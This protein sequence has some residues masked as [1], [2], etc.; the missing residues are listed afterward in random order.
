MANS[1]TATIKIDVN[2]NTHDID[3][4]RRK[5]A[6]LAAQQ[7]TLNKKT[8]A[9]ASRSNNAYAKVLGDRVN[10]FKEHFDQID[11]LTQKAGKALK[12]GIG[13]ASKATALEMAAMGASMLVVHAAFG[14][15]NFLMKAY[16]GGLQLLAVGAAAAGVAISSVAAAMREQAAAMSAFRYGPTELG[17]GI[18]TATAALRGL[19][20]DADLAFLGV[21]NLNAAFQAVNQHAKFDAGSQKMLKSLMDFGAASGNIEGSVKQAGDLVGL[22]QQI[23]NP[24]TGMAVSFMQIKQA[25]NALSPQLSEALRKLRITTK[26]GFIE[27]LNSGELAKAGGVEGQLGVVG[28]TLINQL[29]GYKTRL[30]NMF[31]DLGQPFLVPLKNGMEKIFNIISRSLRTLSGA[32]GG[33]G[34]NKFINGLVSLADKLSTSITK[35][36]LNYL[37]KA[38]GMFSRIGDWFGRVKEFFKSAVEK[39]RPLVDGAKVLEHAF[40]AAFT[41]IKE[42]ISSRFGGFNEFLKANADRAKD[43]GDKVGK[44]VASLLGVVHEFGVIYQN[45][46][47]FVTKL[48]SGA[49]SVANSFKDVLH[50]ITKIGTFFGGGEGGSLF[51]LLGLSGLAKGM[52]KTRGGYLNMSKNAG[53]NLISPLNPMNIGAGGA[54]PGPQVNGVWGSTAAGLQSAGS[55]LQSAGASLQSAAV[56][57]QSGKAT[58]QYNA[59]NGMFNPGAKNPNIIAAQQ[60]LKAGGWKSLTP[61]QQIALIND[62]KQRAAVK[63]VPVGGKAGNRY[64]ARQQWMRQYQVHKMKFYDE[65]SNDPSLSHLTDQEK[66]SRARTM[67]VQAMQMGPASRPSLSSRVK[68]LGQRKRTSINARLGNITNIA[69]SAAIDPMG[70]ANSKSQAFGGWFKNQFSQMTP[71]ELA[72]I[73][74]MKQRQPSWLNRKMSGLRNARERASVGNFSKGINSPLGSIGAS[75]GIG[76]LSQHVGKQS[77]G[78]MALGSM[79]AGSNPLAGLAVAGIGGAMGAQTSAGG[80]LLG[81]GGG[82]ALGMMVA[83]PAGAAVGAALGAIGGAIMGWRNGN[84]ARKKAARESVVQEMQSLVYGSVNAAAVAI[85]NNKNAPGTGNYFSGAVTGAFSDIATKSKALNDYVTYQKQH[86]GQNKDIVNAVYSNQRAYGINMSPEDRNTQLKAAGT[87][88]D[89]MQTESATRYKMAIKLSNAYTD[90]LKDLTSWTG[91]SADEINTLSQSIGYNLTDATKSSVDALKALGLAQVKTADQFNAAL[92]QSYSNAFKPYEQVINRDQQSNSI[93]DALRNFAEKARTGPVS[94]KDIAETMSSVGQ[95]NLALYGG[96]TAKA[97]LQMLEQYNPISG[98]MFTTQANGKKSYLYGMQNTFAKDTASQQVQSNLKSSIIN[99]I[100]SQ[101]IGAAGNSQMTVNGSEVNKTLSTMID[102]AITTGTGWSDIMALLD[103][104]Q[105]GFTN[106]DFSTKAGLSGP[107]STLAFNPM[108]QG[109]GKID[110]SALTDSETKV[111][112]SFIDEMSVLFKN[113]YQDKPDWYTADSFKQLIAAAKVGDTSTPRGS[114]IGDTTTSRLSQ[115]M[116]RH[117]SIDGQ[118]TGSR[119]ITS[120]YRTTGLGSINSDHLTGRALDLTGQNLGQYATITKNAGGFAEFHGVGGDR[121]LHVV[122]GPGAIGDTAVPKVVASV[123]GRSGSQN[124]YYFTISGDGADP[125]TIANRVMAKIENAQRSHRERI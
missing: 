47:P 95:S 92:A 76:L 108:N 72:S 78:A 38:D 15:G 36:I 54:N 8:L 101:L 39:L 52:S 25:A 70:F 32:I 49:T 1:S 106:V 124:N 68:A 41:P 14:T 27:A 86:S 107:L 83:G 3:K 45:L 22:L 57:L 71:Q 67:A 21:K 94:S 96:N 31:A 123:G 93:G 90:K 81:A 9:D 118:L 64:L 116:S 125:E 74:M 18:D 122:P 42:A 46:L 119:T 50:S 104:A 65:I 121:H 63:P 89:K 58:G 88:V 91:K 48:V 11:K 35:L 59:N 6:E 109:S 117:A 26:K 17:K 105:N 23:R 111:F 79:I 37:P 69:N 34:I 87:S 115:T 85:S 51:A 113:T 61:N 24:K 82:A 40:G 13:M 56:G 103:Q 12:E 100:S 43:F 53:L 112:N 84:E 75:L 55:I 5:L 2:A 19:Q 97:N 98:K 4:T 28:G 33:F 102:N 80:G 62:A 60:Q 30:I 110:T 44:F 20:T 16:R 120:G 29:K 99:S 114:G 7:G 73:Q 10:Y 77:Q 66:V